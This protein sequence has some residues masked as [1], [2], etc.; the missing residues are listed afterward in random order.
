VTEQ[1]FDEVAPERVGRRPVWR[2]VAY[3]VGVYLVYSAVRNKFGSAGGPP[4]HA[5][6]IA[7]GH[8]Q[9]VIRF[10]KNV[11]LFIEQTAQSWYLDLPAHGLIQ[12]WNVF[13]G[14]AHFVVTGVALIWLFLRDP[15][16]YP[17]WRNTLA[18]ATLLG[19]IG[20]AAFSLMPPRLLDKT[21]DHYGPPTQQHYGFVDTLEKYPTFWSFD[22]GGLKKLSNQYAAMPSLHMGWST[23]AALV[24]FPLV[25][26]RW[27][28]A[29][30]VLY[31]MAT[32]FCIVVTA[33]HFW[34]DALAGLI[35]LGISYAIGG[36]IADFWQR[37]ERAALSAA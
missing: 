5:N 28:R 30:V 6:G 17:R 18:C 7:F 9:D 25:R 37:R 13:Y 36:R 24:L 10:E 33:N 23:W 19:L 35:V 1:V 20:F 26:R 8:A 11:G 3:I 14:T 29:L 31:P 34:L 21:E 12:V 27:A 2:E 22:S 15:E 4:G 16:R 32:F